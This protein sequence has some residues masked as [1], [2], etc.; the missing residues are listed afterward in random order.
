MVCD[1]YMMFPLD[2]KIFN[3]KYRRTKLVKLTN[4]Y[5]FHNGFQFK[6]GL[7]VDVHP[8]QEDYTKGGIFFT[9]IRKKRKWAHYGGQCMYYIRPV[10]IPDDA[11]VFIYDNMFKADKL[12][13]GERERFKCYCPDST[14]LKHLRLYV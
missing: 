3:K 2:G 10:T 14:I 8:L 1:Y 11:S 4:M 6:T 13:L 5:E 7:N 9:E 12:I